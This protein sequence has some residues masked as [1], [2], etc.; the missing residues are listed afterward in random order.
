MFA[1]AIV[2]APSSSGCRNCSSTLRGKFR[3]FVQEQHAVVRQAHFARPRRARSSADQSRVRH[4]MMRRAERPV[5]QQPHALRQRSRDAVHL[6]R[7]QR[8]GKR[9]RRQDA[10]DSLRQHRLARPRRPDQKHVMIP[11]GRDFDRALRRHLPAHVAKIERSRPVRRGQRCAP[12]VR[13]EAFRFAEERDHFAQVPHPEHA[14]AVR[15]RRLRRIV[16]RDQQVLIPFAACA[17]RDRQ[18]TAHRP[19]RRRRGIALLQKD[20]PPPGPPRPSLPESPA[21]SAD[22]T[23]RLLSA[24]L[25]APG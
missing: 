16:R 25:R 7:L 3:Q 9:Q 1:R 8:F 22:R 10:G 14:H 12:G 23:P 19:D 4:R 13:L 20:G 5:L 11:R 21:P 2:T 15:D 18:G 6:G 24:H 17:S